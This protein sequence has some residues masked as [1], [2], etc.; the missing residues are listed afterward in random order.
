MRLSCSCSSSSS[1][2]VSMTTVAVLT[3]LPHSATHLSSY[4]LPSTLRQKSNRCNEPCFYSNSQPVRADKI[5]CFSRWTSIFPGRAQWQI[6]WDARDAPVQILSFHAVF[7]KCF[8]NNRLGHPSRELGPT[9]GNPR[10]GTL[11][12]I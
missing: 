9:P 6:E 3:S 1:I 2:T 4:S 12:S 7:G 10:V 5:P 8:Q 11:N